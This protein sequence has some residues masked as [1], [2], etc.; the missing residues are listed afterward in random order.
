MIYQ[1]FYFYIYILRY[2]YVLRD[3]CINHNIICDSQIGTSFLEFWF[4]FHAEL[5]LLIGQ[6]LCSVPYRL[7]AAAQ[8]SGCISIPA[9]GVCVQRLVGLCGTGRAEDEAGPCRRR[10]YHRGSS[11]QCLV[12]TDLSFFPLLYVNIFNRQ[13]GWTVHLSGNSSV[14]RNCRWTC[15][16]PSLPSVF[17]FASFS[18]LVC[19]FQVLTA[20]LCSETPPSRSPKHTLSVFLDFLVSWHLQETDEITL[21]LCFCE[22]VRTQWLIQSL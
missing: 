10:L 7:L 1:Y 18:S 9:A 5:Q 20:P 8:G 11:Q 4:L 16:F 6:G 17:A 22:E 19:S 12:D 21:Y 3:I 15:I 13:D 2:I 14:G